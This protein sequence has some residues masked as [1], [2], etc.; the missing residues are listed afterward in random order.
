VDLVAD[1]IGSS[2][3]YYSVSK[4]NEFCETFDVD[5]Y[6]KAR[7]GEYVEFVIRKWLREGSQAGTFLTDMQDALENV[8]EGMKTM[9]EAEE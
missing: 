3:N 8:D 4:Y 9:A 6:G 5:K 2:E 1:Y 7:V